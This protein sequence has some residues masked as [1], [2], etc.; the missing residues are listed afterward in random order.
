MSDSW[1]AEARANELEAEVVNLSE[2]VVLAKAAIERLTNAI[3]TLYD[4]EGYL[5]AEVERL[6]KALSASE[7][8]YFRL[9][10]KAAQFRDEWQS[11]EGVVQRVRSIAQHHL[12][13][14]ASGRWVAQEIL[15]TLDG[16]SDER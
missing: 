6:T 11:L 15:V 3:A 10:D 4:S 13:A 1:I 7:A 8:D 5:A 9:R 2:E 12:E 16:G 14:G